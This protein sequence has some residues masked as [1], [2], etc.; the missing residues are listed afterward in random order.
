L[1]FITRRTPIAD[2]SD[3]QI[4]NLVVTPLVKTF[5]GDI[6]SHETGFNETMTGLFPQDEPSNLNDHRLYGGQEGFLRFPYLWSLYRTANGALLI[7]R[8]GIK[9]EATA[10]YGD[11]DKGKAQL[12]LRAGLRDRRYDGTKWGNDSAL[13][14]F[15]YDDPNLHARF[16]GENVPTVEQSLYGF[17]PFTRVADVT[18]DAEFDEFVRQPFAFLDRPEVFLKHFRRAW[19]SDRAPGQN[20]KAMPDVSKKVLQNFCKLAKSKGY[21]YIEGANSHYHVCMWTSSL[22]YGF[23]LPQQEQTFKRFQDGIARLKAAGVKLNR[24]QESWVVVLQSLRPIALIPPELYLGNPD[25]IWPQ[26]N[27]SPQNLWVYK[28]LD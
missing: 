3:K 13:L 10:W 28:K 19:I 16:F 9:F 23:T 20:A 15:P 8:D 24:T 6:V 17:M 4:W 26:D 14:G 25:L 5:L 12:I 21:Q 1:D 27:I 22:G 11:I 2:V 7:R 18:G